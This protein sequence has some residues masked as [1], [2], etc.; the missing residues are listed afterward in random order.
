MLRHVAAFLLIGTV[1]ALPRTL[2]AQGPEK[3]DVRWSSDLYF[4][5]LLPGL[6]TTVS[7][8]DPGAA[9]FEIYGIKGTEISLEWLLPMD[10]VGESSGALLP[11]TFGSMSAAYSSTNLA[12][13]ALLFDPALPVN[14]FIDEREKALVWI[15]GTVTPPFGGAADRYSAPI[16]LIVSVVSNE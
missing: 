8:L 1:S 6:M 10:L 11:V 7:P 15:G 9:T 4:G 3:L 13:D 12:V 5:R 14:A 16:T 2:A